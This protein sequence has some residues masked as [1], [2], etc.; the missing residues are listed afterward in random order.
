[1]RAASGVKPHVGA[2]R[3]GA[4]MDLLLVPGAK[5]CAATACASREP[6]PGNG[7]GNPRLVWSNYQ[8]GWCT[9]P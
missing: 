8:V 9:L 2:H 7:A 6:H 1:M 5:N 3:D 4:Q